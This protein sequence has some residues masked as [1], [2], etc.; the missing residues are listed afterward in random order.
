MRQEIVE[1]MEEVAKDRLEHTL[2]EVPG[3]ENDG[4]DQAVTAVQTLKSIEE[5]EFK[6]YLEEE[7]LELENEKFSKSE[8]DKSIDRALDLIKFG[9]GLLIG[10]GIDWLTKNQFLT[11]VFEFET[12]GTF[13][14]AAGRT[15]GNFFKFKK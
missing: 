8:E 6:A 9:S 5:S 11:R 3:S 10:S 15:I 13:T 12:K 14:T 4:F 2:N 7:K 1:L